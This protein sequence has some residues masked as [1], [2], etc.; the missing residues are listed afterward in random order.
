MG[1]PARR[2][3]WRRPLFPLYVGLLHANPGAGEAAWE[4]PAPVGAAGTQ[5]GRQTTE[6]AVG[7]QIHGTQQPD[8]PHPLPF[9][10]TLSQFKWVVRSHSP[11][12]TFQGNV[13][14][15]EKKQ[16]EKWRCVSKYFCTKDFRIYLHLTGTMLVIWI[17]FFFSSQQLPGS[18]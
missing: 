7:A 9:T 18:K 3:A 8:L 14:E 17:F 11:H 1:R 12:P 15:K 4:R 2:A 16:T 13:T 5:Q 6:H 10:L